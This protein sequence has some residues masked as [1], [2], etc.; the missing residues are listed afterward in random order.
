MVKWVDG[1]WWIEWQTGWILV[2]PT[3]HWTT[4]L[5]PTYLHKSKFVPNG[6]ITVHI[7]YID[8]LSLDDKGSRQQ[9]RSK[10]ESF[11]NANFLI[12]QLNPMVWP[13]IGIVSE[14]Q[15]Q[16]GS[17]YRVWVEKSE[18]Y[19]EHLFDHSFLTVALT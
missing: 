3:S 11:Q 8:S 19:H 5:D 7:H 13:L 18:T 1:E 12:S 2:Q 16:W 14:R 9:I 4:G 10:I 6:L 17:H 15:F